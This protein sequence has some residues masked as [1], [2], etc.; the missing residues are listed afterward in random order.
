MAEQIAEYTV[1][2]YSAVDAQ[3]EQIA[4]REQ[5]LTNKLRLANLKQAIILGCGAMIAFGLLVVLLAWAYRIAF[6]QK[7][8]VIEKTQVI[9]K[10]VQPQEIIIKTPQGTVINDQ[11]DG[12]SALTSKIWGETS[13]AGNDLTPVGANQ[14]GNSAQLEPSKIGNRSVTTFTNV[15]SGMSGYV[16]V[17][18][19]WRWDKVSAEFP[20]SQYCYLEK[21]KSG[22]TTENVHL[23][24]KDNV[25]SQP[26]SHYTSTEG[27]NANL[28]RTVWDNALKKCVWFK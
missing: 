27:K 6:P 26:T 14:G 23:G 12:T 2:D 25:N 10:I 11:T 9:E 21:I 18:T 3:I 19:G 20:K 24:Y 7:P 4:K 17:V 28:S 22:V 13:T 15:A 1:R 8:D 16:N 5:V